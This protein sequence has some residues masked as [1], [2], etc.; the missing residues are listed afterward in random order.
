MPVAKKESQ[1]RAKQQPHECSTECIEQK[2]GEQESHYKAKP[3][4]FGAATDW[5]VKPTTTSAITTPTALE[6][7]PAMERSRLEAP[8]TISAP[9][10]RQTE[11]FWT[12]V[13]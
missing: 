3:Y 11:A 6:R 8:R 5:K 1:A 10:P 9:Q 12:T 7:Q 2:R 4:S 13:L